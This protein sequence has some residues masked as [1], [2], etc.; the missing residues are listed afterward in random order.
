MILT[1]AAAAAIT[2]TCNWSDRGLDPYMGDLPSAVDTYTQIPK[3]TREALKAKMRARQYDDTAHI[4][5][6]GIASATWEY[7]PLRMMHFGNGSK[8]CGIV[9]TSM[10][11]PKDT[12]ERA[13]IYTVGEWSIAVPS[14]CRNVSLITRG[15]RISP[16]P[17][18]TTEAPPALVPPLPVAVPVSVPDVTPGPVADAV[19]RQSFAR[20][21]APEP[22]PDGNQELDT[23]EDTWRPLLPP[24]VPI[25]WPTLPAPLLGPLWVQPVAFAA[26]PS[27]LTFAPV[28]GVAPMVID[29]KKVTPI[30]GDA[31][32]SPAP[33][34]PVAPVPEPVK[35]PDSAVP[36]APVPEPAEWALMLLGLG[37][38]AWQRRGAK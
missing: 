12:G 10:W 37:W 5:S 15:N 32:M 3:P 34:A 26:T 27:V 8:L 33:G 7:G 28:P 22:I 36:V 11:A 6:A 35:L 29:A 9:N 18:L 13:L 16:P 2:A 23:P 30:I 38:V 17:S 1:L 4:T 31:V 21:S 19:P 14:V 25:Y 20:L 24:A